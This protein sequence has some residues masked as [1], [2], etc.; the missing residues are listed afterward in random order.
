M[1]LTAVS[2]E[3]DPVD[4]LKIG[5]YMMNSKYMVHKKFSRGYMV[6]NHIILNLKL[7]LKNKKRQEFERVQLKMYRKTRNSSKG[8]AHITIFKN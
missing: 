7:F 2:H 3:G 5:G 4:F 1:E 6:K 8:V